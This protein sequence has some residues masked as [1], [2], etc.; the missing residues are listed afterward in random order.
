MTFKLS[1]ETSTLQSF[2]KDTQRLICESLRRPFGHS[3][4]EAIGVARDE[5]SI[6]LYHY[7]LSEWI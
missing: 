2:D 6:V 4:E 7:R 5:E 1:D 3:V